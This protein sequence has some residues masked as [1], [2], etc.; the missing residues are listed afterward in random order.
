MT[1]QPLFWIIFILRKPRVANFTDIIKITVM[2][3]KT[4]FKDSKKLKELETMY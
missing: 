3:A 1:S 2:F 4:T